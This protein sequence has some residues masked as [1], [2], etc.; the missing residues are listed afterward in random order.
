MNQA[1]PNTAEEQQPASEPGTQLPFILAGM[2]AIVALYGGF[3]WWQ[4]EQAALDRQQAISS[5]QIGPPLTDFEI[6]ERNGTTFRS[7]DMKG[8]VWATTYFFTTCPGSCLR[9]N[10]NI[11][12]LHNMPELEDVTWVS[13]T[14]DPDTD[15]LPVLREYADR[16]EA[17][18]ERW[19]FC[20]A[21]LDII[22]QIGLGM[23]LPIFR[24][25]HKDYAVV[26]DRAGNLRGMFDAT[27]KSHAQRLRTLLL[28]CLEE[29]V[30]T[31][32][33]LGK[34]EKESP[35]T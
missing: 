35:S 27:R 6:D 23:N 34:Q 2:L 29:D 30:S 5:T 24:K 13:I 3:K 32:E 25:G 17:D 33:A 22:K 8:K 31:A 28:K 11:K 21:D 16:Y 26:F 4:V 20:R 19:L 9:L 18:P 15:T 12:L 14:C 1:E 10:A 7:A